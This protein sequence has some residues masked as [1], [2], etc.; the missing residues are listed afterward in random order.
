MTPLEALTALARVAEG[1]ERAAR[2]RS[3]RS[4]LSRVDRGHAGCAAPPSDDPAYLRVA[5]TS[6]PRDLDPRIGVDEA[7][8]R[9]HQLVFSPLLK[10]DSELRVVP[11]LAASVETPD[12]TTY[13]VK[14]RTDVRFHDGSL[15]DRGRCRVH[16]RQLP[17][18][19]LRQRTEGRVSRARRRRCRR[20]ADR[21]IQAEGAVRIVSDPARDGHRQARLEESVDAADRHRPVHVRAL[22]S[23]R[24]RRARTRS[25][26]ISKARR[27][28]PG[29]C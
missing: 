1:G 5:I 25:T 22:G 9:M 11:H 23:R 10:L 6:S 24:S 19:I 13:I 20:S 2:M 29:S 26:A 15:P 21:A 28:I 7:S 16:V 27:A 17:R 8:Q 4:L 3:R 14:L 18:K 12:P